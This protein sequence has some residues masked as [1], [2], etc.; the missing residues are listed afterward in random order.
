MRVHHPLQQGL[1]QHT[2]YFLYKFNLVRVHHPLQQGLRHVCFAPLYPNNARASASSITTSIKMLLCLLHWLFSVSTRTS[3]VEQGL[4][5]VVR[6]GVLVYWAGKT[7]FHKLINSPTH[8]LANSLTR[9]LTNSP[10]HPLITSPTHNLPNS[11]PPQLKNLN[12][13]FLL[14]N[15]ALFFTPF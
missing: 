13:Y 4:F 2:L 9:L 14:Y 8:Q 11:K 7:V 5:G 12:C 15:S 1:R 6:N 10:T 3:S